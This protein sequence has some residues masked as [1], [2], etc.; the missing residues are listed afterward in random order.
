MGRG[1]LECT[2]GE[3]ASVNMGGHLCV[4]PG[5]CSKEAG[6]RATIDYVLG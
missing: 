2:L 4:N 1:V 6:C 5:V 3:M